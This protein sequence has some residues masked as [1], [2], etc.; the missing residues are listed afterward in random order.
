MDPKHFSRFFYFNHYTLT[1][2][3]EGISHEESCR[4]PGPQGNTMNWVLGHVV[5]SRNDILA[6][7]G[8]PPVWGAQEATPYARGSA[9]MS[10]PAAARPFPEILQALER[11]QTSIRER[12]D[13][14]S[15]ADLDAPTEKATVGEELAFLQF[16]ESYHAGQVGLLRRLLGKEGVIK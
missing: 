11:S 14:M 5:A 16:H 12:L 7:L 6:L 3:A 2:H 4:R 13:E 10:N 9:G 8:R 1:K 15:A